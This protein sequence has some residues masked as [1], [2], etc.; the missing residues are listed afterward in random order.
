MFGRNYPDDKFK[1]ACNMLAQLLD[2]DQDG[3]ADDVLVVKKIRYNQHGVGLYLDKK[4]LESLDSQ[5]ARN[6]IAQPLYAFEV[7]PTCSGSDETSQCR[8]ASIEEIFHV[9]SSIG[10][11]AAY[12]RAFGE[13]TVTTQ[14]GRSA[15]QIDMDKAR[16]GFFLDIPNKYPDGAIYHYDDK[17]CAYDC[18]AT[19][20]IYWAMT[21]ILGGQG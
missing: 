17:T 10:L 18:Q 13:C 14:A 21:S 12:P 20:M 4:D 19:E 8:D 9:V 11:S 7:E 16:G 5:M 15:L 3:C 2:N 1:H 6:F